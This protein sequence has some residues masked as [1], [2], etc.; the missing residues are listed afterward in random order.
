M[1]EAIEIN[2]LKGMKLL[3]SISDEQYSNKAIP[4]YFS[5][6]G[7]HIRHIL[8]VFSCVLRDFSTGN[9]DLTQRERNALVEEKVTLGIAYFDEILHQIKVLS[10][11]D[12]QTAVSVTDDLGLGKCASNST[13]GAILMQAQSHTTHHYASIGNIIYQLKIKL[14][15]AD[16]GYNPTTVKKI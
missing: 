7:C 15:D 11:K 3:N 5:S 10:Q 14:P 9:I 16:F 12:L 2:L 8:D 13:L 4:P 1:I 6:I